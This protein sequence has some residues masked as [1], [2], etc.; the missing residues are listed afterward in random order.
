MRMRCRVTLADLK[1]E[2]RWAEGVG[3]NDFNLV[4]YSLLLTILHKT[5][6][7]NENRSDW[8]VV[9]GSFTI[10]LDITSQ[11]FFISLRNYSPHQSFSVSD[12]P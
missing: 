2:G 9:I 11:V 12:G 10:H 6:E 8:L 4:M 5:N 3:T 1:K 7:L